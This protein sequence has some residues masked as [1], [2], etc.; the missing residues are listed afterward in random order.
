M[1]INSYIAIFFT[2]VFLGKFFML[3]S[4]FL[5]SILETE[6]IAWVNSYCENN[7]LNSSEENKSADFEQAANA[8][9]INADAICNS[10][11]NFSSLNWPA[12]QAEPNFQYYDYRN[13]AVISAYHDKFY[14][15][16]KVLIG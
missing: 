5:G 3:D 10:P 4:K 8:L 14:P 2:L 9:V 1:K 12:A 15:P 11:F 6:N 16:P 13:P 7:L